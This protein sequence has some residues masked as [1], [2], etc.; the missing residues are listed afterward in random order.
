[1]TPRCARIPGKQNLGGSRIC[2]YP[3]QVLS[4]SNWV[5]FAECRGSPTEHPNDY[6]TFSKA[7][8]VCTIRSPPWAFHM[9]RPSAALPKNRRTCHPAS[10]GRFQNPKAAQICTIPT[11]PQTIHSASI[12]G[13]PQK[14]SDLSPRLTR[15]IPKFESRTNLHNPT[16]PRP[17]PFG[18]HRRPPPQIV[19]PVTP[20]HPADS[21]TRKPHK[22]AQ[23]HPTRPHP[24]GVHRRPSSK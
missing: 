6:S 2:R 22:S 11:Q 3:R 13:P 15:P 23:S 4:T 21:K 24:L 12:G 5:R 18:V 8:Q 9:R 1:M 16:Q 19:G 14:S 17:H 10:P 20:P 7:A